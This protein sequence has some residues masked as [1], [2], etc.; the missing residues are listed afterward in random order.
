MDKW[1]HCRW[2]ETDSVFHD[3]VNLAHV[4]S[5]AKS[6][7]SAQHAAICITHVDIMLAISRGLGIRVWS[8]L[9]ACGSFKAGCSNCWHAIFTYGKFGSRDRVRSQVRKRNAEAITSKS[10]SK[11][12]GIQFRQ[13]CQ[14]N[15]ASCLPFFF[16]I[17]RND[18]AMSETEFDVMQSSL[19]LFITF[20][21]EASHDP[22]SML[23]LSID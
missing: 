17:C 21:L 22:W 2:F 20:Y 6:S 7:T 12:L 3:S 8:F 9:H 19:K 13:Y 11:T 15:M 14:L 16:L 10:N 23:L 5:H 18:G 1:W 4:S